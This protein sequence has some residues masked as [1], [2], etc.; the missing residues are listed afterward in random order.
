MCH[1]YYSP[2]SFLWRFVFSLGG[3]AWQLTEFII[4]VFLQILGLPFVSV[5]QVSLFSKITAEKTQGE[6]L[7]HLLDKQRHDR[8]LGSFRGKKL[9]YQWNW[10]HI[11]RPYNN[12]RSKPFDVFCAVWGILQ[13]SV[14]EYVVQWGV[15]PPF[16]A[17]YGLEALPRTCM[18]W[19]GWWLYCWS[20]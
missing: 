9:V 20:C 4:G 13:V 14:R 8:V 16:W 7:H 15:W 5:A 1:I 11:L 17:H 12:H 18:S 10:L 2:F 19:W 3:F 6:K